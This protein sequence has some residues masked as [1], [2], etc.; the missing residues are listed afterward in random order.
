[1]TQVLTYPFA[2]WSWECPPLRVQTPANLVEFRKFRVFCARRDGTPHSSLGHPSLPPVGSTNAHHPLRRS[3]RP[4]LQAV[5][6]LS[7]R[8]AHCIP[9]NAGATTIPSF[10]E[11]STHSKPSTPPPPHHD[12]HLSLPLTLNASPHPHY[13]N[14]VAEDSSSTKALRQRTSSTT[15]VL[16]L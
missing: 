3:Y 5:H 13:L 8:G 11:V 1:M 9:A 12:H 15:T 14:V 2:A 7:T 6:H 4:A 10:Q 16:L